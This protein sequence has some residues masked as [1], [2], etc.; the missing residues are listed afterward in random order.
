MVQGWTY[1]AIAKQTNRHRTTISR[2]L[3]RNTLENGDYVPT[4]AHQQAQHRRSEASSQ[5]RA[6]TVQR[7]QEFA[8]WL[9]QHSGKTSPE[10]Y[11]GRCTKVLGK[12]SLSISWLYIL[13]WCLRAQGNKLFQCLPRHGTKYRRRAPNTASASKIPDRVDIDARPAEVETRTQP[14]HWEADTII[15]RGHQGVILT[16]IERHSRFTAMRV[17]PNRQAL[18]IAWA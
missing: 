5:P 4:E 13:I 18:M 15:R 1:T 16:V 2:E 12:P 11:H 17:L 8:D 7:F 9:R 10:L 6:T 3:R 14:G